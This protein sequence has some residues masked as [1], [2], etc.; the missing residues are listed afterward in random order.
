MMMMMMVA[1]AGLLWRRSCWWMAVNIT[2]Q[3]L[4]ENGMELECEMCF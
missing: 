2:D 3:V 4:M 1:A